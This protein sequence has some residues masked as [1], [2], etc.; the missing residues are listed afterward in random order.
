MLLCWPPQTLPL[1]KLE[2]DASA[3]GAGAVLLQEDKYGIDHPVCYFSKKFKKHQLHYSTIEKEALALLLALQHFEVYVSS[4]PAPTTVF[5][6]H[7]P[8][9]FLKQMQNSNQRVMCWSLL[10]QDFNIEIRG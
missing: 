1:F 6:D 5:S 2:L 9:V 4:N 3:L 10:L 8:L 7:N